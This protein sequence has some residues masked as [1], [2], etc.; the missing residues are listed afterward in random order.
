MSNSCIELSTNVEF[1]HR[2]IGQYGIH[3]ENYWQM[4][5]SNRAKL[6]SKI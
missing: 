4:W 6:M 2:I 3:I 1:I 5:S